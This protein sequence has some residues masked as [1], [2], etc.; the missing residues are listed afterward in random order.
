M[1]KWVYFNGNFAY[2]NSK[3]GFFNGKPGFMLLDR[4]ID[5]TGDFEPC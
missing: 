1:G 5:A 4:P 3:T 2:F